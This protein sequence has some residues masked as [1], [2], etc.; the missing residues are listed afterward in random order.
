MG[1]ISTPIWTL[2][3]YFRTKRTNGTRVA[4]GLSFKVVFLVRFFRAS[5]FSDHIFGP[6]RNGLG[7]WSVFWVRFLQ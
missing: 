5:K 7:F 6:Q 2:I 1:A 3:S 4:P